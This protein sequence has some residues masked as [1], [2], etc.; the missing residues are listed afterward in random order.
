MICLKCSYYT[1]NE[2]KSPLSGWSLNKEKVIYLGYG[3]E[4]IRKYTK[5]YLLQNKLVENNCIIFDPACSTGQFLYELKKHFPN[6]K[7]IGQDLSKEM[8]DY[9]R[10]YVDEIYHGNAIKTF[11]TDKSV[12][13]LILRFLNSEVV[14]TI[15]AYRLFNKLIATVKNNGLIICFGHTPVLIRQKYFLKRNDLK[16][17]HSNGYDKDTNSI[18][19]FYILKKLY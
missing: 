14:T 13:I 4:H 11:I 7:T 8:V 5:E 9:A 19:Q 16:I 12:D 6:C 18:F 15:T 3:E 2:K 1:K 17:L 10:N